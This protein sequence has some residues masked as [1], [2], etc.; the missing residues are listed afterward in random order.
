VIGDDISDFV[1]RHHAHKLMG[2]V[3]EAEGRRKS[4]FGR[5]R[6]FPFMD[7]PGWNVRG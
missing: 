4:I 5:M 1:L 3:A 2:F 6:A 7:V